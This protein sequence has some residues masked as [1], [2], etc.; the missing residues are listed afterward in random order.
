MNT[1]TIILLA[2]IVW[3]LFRIFKFW[4]RRQT[5]YIPKDIKEAVIKREH[6]TCAVCTETNRQL[7]DFHHKKR[8]SD[9]GTNTEENIQV[10][11]VN[12]H[13]L[14]TRNNGG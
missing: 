10:L 1:S 4:E 3:A 11:C 13:A 2:L 14:I 5:R 9:G 12:H 6:G 7:F 8:Y